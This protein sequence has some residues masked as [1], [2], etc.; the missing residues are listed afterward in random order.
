MAVDLSIPNSIIGAYAQGRAE[1]LQRLKDAQAQTQFQ[2]EQ[3]FKQ[4]QLSQQQQE[5][6]QRLQQAQKQFEDS[7]KL[8]REVHAA[9]QKHE[10]SMLGLQQAIASLGFQEHF[11]TG[12]GVPPGFTNLGPPPG[13]DTGERTL[14]GGPDTGTGISQIQATDPTIYAKQQ[15]ELEK[16]GLR[17]KA[18]IATE[19]ENLKLKQKQEEDTLAYR[20]AL[21]VANLNGQYRLA[22]AKEA[23]DAQRENVLDKPFDPSVLRDNFGIS[24]YQIL[25]PR[26]AA[27]LNLIKPLTP[28]EKDELATLNN[29]ESSVH[30]LKDKLDASNYAYFRTDTSGATAETSAKIF[31][32]KDPYNS[33]V[34]AELGRVLGKEVVEEAGKTLSAS[35]LKILQSH[36]PDISHFQ[37]PEDV[38]NKLN[39]LLDSLHQMQ[40]TRFKVNKGEVDKV[41]QEN[42]WK[43]IDI[44]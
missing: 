24:N 22:A 27:G 9:T 41:K 39:N 23:R 12:K 11:Q 43:I 25:T 15:A 38:K 14:I 42:S 28:K 8:T 33:Q 37:S 20:R 30:A 18:D 4:Q 31:G 17:P 19:L 2:Q 34:R 6:Q 3:Q 21:E 5:E 13:L 29:L 16:I 7:Q 35:E 10:A 1:A 44:K 36:I 40:A 26:T 32:E